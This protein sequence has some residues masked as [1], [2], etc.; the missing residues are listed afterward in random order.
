MKS[1]G[2]QEEIL[3]QLRRRIRELKN[4]LG[5]CVFSQKAQEKFNEIESMLNHEADRKPE[6]MGIAAQVSL[7]PL[8]VP[9]LTPFINQAL[10]IFKKMGLETQP[11]SMSTIISGD[12]D[13]VWK[14]LRDAFAATAIQ[15]ELVMA[16]TVS[17]ACPIRVKIRKR[18]NP[19]T[20]T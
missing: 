6:S 4:E 11:G 20:H 7:Y 19:K 15:G 8:R 18:P 10:D 2:Q 9:S 3:K 1:I 12:S 16:V 17:N 5:N 14:A 13:T